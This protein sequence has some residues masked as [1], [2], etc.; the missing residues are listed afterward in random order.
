MCTCWEPFPH[1]N[2]DAGIDSGQ[3]SGQFHVVDAAE[4]SAAIDRLI[5]PSDA[6][7]VA[8]INIPQAYALQLLFHLVRDQSGVFHLRK[9]GDDDIALAGAFDGVGTAVFLDG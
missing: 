3:L 9:G 2:D 4:L 1:Q 5:L 6:E 8:R 7:E